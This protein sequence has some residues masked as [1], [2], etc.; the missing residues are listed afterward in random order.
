VTFLSALCYIPVIPTSL[1]VLLA[2]SFRWFI[3]SNIRV[4][5]NVGCRVG[6]KGECAGG[7]A[8]CKAPF[9][10]LSIVTP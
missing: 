9:R 7:E 10:S 2:T 3:A 1:K 5:R 6:N 8:I 4:N